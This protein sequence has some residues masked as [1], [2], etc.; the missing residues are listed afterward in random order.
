[1][2]PAW[3]SIMQLTS[4]MRASAEAGDWEALRATQQSRDSELRAF[5]EVQ[6]Q[7]EPKLREAIERLLEV[8]RGTMALS[9]RA[10]AEVS[11]ARRRLHTGR[12]AH[13]AY[14]KG[15]ELR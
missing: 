1:M 14:T 3:R 13:Q 7:D 12:R 8:D 9:E 10:L 2:S 5:F 15:G 6:D 11:E 4:A